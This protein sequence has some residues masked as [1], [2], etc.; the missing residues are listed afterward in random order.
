MRR[1]ASTNC[2]AFSFVTDQ[3]YQLPFISQPGLIMISRLLLAYSSSASHRTLSHSPRAMAGKSC[4]QLDSLL[5]IGTPTLAIISLPQPGKPLACTI[6]LAEYAAEFRQ[7]RVCSSR[8][9]QNSTGLS[10]IWDVNSPMMLEQ[11]LPPH[12]SPHCTPRCTCPDD[13]DGGCAAPGAVA[14]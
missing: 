13:G 3:R 2:A 9:L 4:C 7:S 5:T 6:P 10:P 12:G 14:L 8:K 1:K 11:P